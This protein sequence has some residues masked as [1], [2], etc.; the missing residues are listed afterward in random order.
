MAFERNHGSPVYTSIR[1]LIGPMLLSAEASG[2]P[3]P[4]GYSYAMVSKSM[5]ETMT[6]WHDG[7]N[8][9]CTLVNTGLPQKATPTELSLSI[10][11][12]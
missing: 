9:L 4:E 12:T 5:A 1:P 7:N 2:T 6:I 3:S 11:A 8:V 10:F